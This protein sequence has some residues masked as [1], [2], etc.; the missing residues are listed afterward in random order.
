M[1]L[2]LGPLGLQ[3]RARSR[4]GMA[5]PFH[6]GERMKVTGDAGP[7]PGGLLQAEK[8]CERRDG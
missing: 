2:D 1:A 8:N 5:R 4:P 6:L 7:G 3:F